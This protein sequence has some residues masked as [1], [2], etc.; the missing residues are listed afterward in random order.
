[1]HRTIMTKFFQNLLLHETLNIMYNNTHLWASATSVGDLL[2]WLYSPTISIFL[3]TST[4][5][6]GITS[7]E[8]LTCSP[9]IGDKPCL[10]IHHA[11]VNG[12]H[13]SALKVWNDFNTHLF[14]YSHPRVWFVEFI[15]LRLD[16][17]HGK[18]RQVFLNEAASPHKGNYGQFY[19]SR[20]E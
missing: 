15:L 9:S 16:D 4:V 13:L 5:L 20:L 14:I 19:I 17:S 12:N 7:T 11:S 10:K 8:S 6:V 3:L 2:Q 1:M 18:R